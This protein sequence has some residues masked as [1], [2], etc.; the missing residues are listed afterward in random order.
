MTRAFPL[1]VHGLPT[2]AQRE[3]NVEGTILNLHARVGPGPFQV[4]DMA[5]FKS[6]VDTE[7]GS[8]NPLVNLSQHFT[9]DP[10]HMTQVTR[11]CRGSLSLPID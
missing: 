1:A 9:R 11:G 10:T 4:R 2:R 5:A 3:E 6:L 8:I 7:C